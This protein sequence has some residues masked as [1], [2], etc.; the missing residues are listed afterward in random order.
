MVFIR[1]THS[2]N[3]LQFCIFITASNSLLVKEMF[4]SRLTR[5]GSLAPSQRQQ[6]SRK[7]TEFKSPFDFFKRKRTQAEHKVSNRKI[8]ITPTWLKRN[9][10]NIM[11]RF[12]ECFF[13]FFQPRKSKMQ[14]PVLGTERKGPST[15]AYHFKV[16]FKILLPSPS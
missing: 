1:Q 8:L 16:I 14:R 12:N 11:P 3:S 2:Y 7:A 6:K 13:F 9:G 10:V 4:Q 5:T 15:Q